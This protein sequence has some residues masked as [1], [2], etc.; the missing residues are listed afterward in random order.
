MDSS[1]IIKQ[2]RDKTIFY[3]LQ[4]QVSTAKVVTSDK[5]YT[6]PDYETKTEYFNGQYL[7]T[8]N[9]PVTK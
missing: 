4:A 6:F 3:S 8:T 5:S 1:E 2:L 7:S 9:T